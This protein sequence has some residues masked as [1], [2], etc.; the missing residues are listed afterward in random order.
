MSR[1]VLIINI[2][3]M[4][5]LVQTVPLL[6]RLRHERPE[7]E[8]D[9]VVDV[10]F[11]PV[12]AL[13]PGFRQV[14]AFNFHGLVDDSRAMA[15]DLV[16]LYADVE[17]W[18]KP[19]RDA[20]YDRIVNLTFNRRSG[21]MA[22]CIGAPDIRG[23][24]V[25]ADGSTLVRD[26]WMAYFTDL[27]HYRR[28]NRFNLVDLYA[29]GGSGPGPFSPLAVTVPRKAAEWAKSFLRLA[30]RSIS[31]SPALNV[32]PKLWIAVQAGASEAIKAWRPEYFG[33]TMAALSHRLRVG[34]VMIG[35]KQERG[36]VEEAIAAYRA[37]GGFSPL[38][39]AVGQT[40]LPELAALLAECRLL[41][42][43]DTGP[44][45]LAVGVGTPVIDLSVGHVDFRETGPYGPG[46][47]VI[48]PDIDCAPCGF[49]HICFH[50]ACKDR[51]DCD[52][53]AELGLYTLHAGSFPAHATG[54]RLYESAVDEDGLADYVLRAGRSDPLTEWYGS[55]WRRYWFES[56]TRR[57]SRRAPLSTPAPD[58]EAAGQVF[59]R[60]QPLAD[61]LV[62]EAEKLA[63]LSRQCPLPVKS[64]KE[65]Q[66]RFGEARQHAVRVAASSPAFGPPT[67]AFLREAS[68]AED[69]G[70]P[71]L[72]LAQLRACRVWRKRLA[73]VACLLGSVKKTEIGIEHV[74]GVDHSRPSSVPGFQPTV[75]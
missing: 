49:D 57:P 50:H 27:H 47:W 62:A 67:V 9:L 65:A 25:S 44:M 53:V 16:S 18:V 20:R 4:G 52:Q 59:S 54:I 31:H 39:N 35:T 69:E 73:E 45:H 32:K 75:N 61:Q 41:L 72:A 48:Q 56:L 46:H 28:L 5:D 10:S 38:C 68:N 2:T 12:A 26:P 71:A 13:L 14:F 74:A 7:V 36:M 55:F 34:F 37:A 15:K 8:V 51:I 29:L 33:R 6:A 43:N 64:L 11:A 19:L 30:V 1:Q 58:Y 22:S 23:V 3:R 40:T 21:L 42:T 66:A 63:Q 70:L 24:S 17:A 60:L